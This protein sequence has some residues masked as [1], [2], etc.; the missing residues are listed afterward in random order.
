L[1][2]VPQQQQQQQQQPHQQQ[3]HQQ[4]QQHQQQAQQQF[5]DEEMVWHDESQSISAIPGAS[6]HFYPSNFPLP[7]HL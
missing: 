3:L 4:Q 2:P 5:D 1:N 7:P 6:H